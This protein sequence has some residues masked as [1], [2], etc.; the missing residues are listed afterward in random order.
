MQQPIEFDHRHHV[1]D[2]GIDCRYCHDAVESAPYAGVPAD[3]ALHGLP[4]ADLEPEPAAGAGAREPT[5]RTGRSPGA[6]VHRLPGLRLL[7]PLDPR[8]QGRRLRHLPRP[9]GSDGAACSRWRR[10][11]WAGASTATAT[12]R[13]TS[14]RPSTITDMDWRPPRRPGERARLASSLT[15]QYQRPHPNQLHHMPPMSDSFPLPVAGLAF[16]VSVATHRWRSFRSASARRVRPRSRR[17]GLDAPRS[18]F[19]SLARLAR[20]RRALGLLRR[21]RRS[22]SSVHAAARRADAREP[23]PL[24][25]GARRSTGYARGCSSPRARGGRSRSRATRTTR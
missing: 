16:R 5:S 9:R 12:P 13:R 17:E 10:S 7:Q 24:R 14:G 19:A 11:P 4:R 20:R 15:G 23:A 22:A 3:R 6:A 8:E 2:D 21:R 25:D 1:G 18:C